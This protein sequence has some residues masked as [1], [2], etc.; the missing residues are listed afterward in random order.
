[1]NFKIIF[2]L[3][4]L[5]AFADHDKITNIIGT[6][7][8]LKTRDHSFAGSIQNALAYG[9]FDH[10]NFTSKSTLHFK[11][12]E[13]TVNFLRDPITKKI[14]GIVLKNDDIAKE[15]KIFLSKID[16]ATQSLIFN[17]NDQEIKVQIE[18]EKF[19]NNHFHNPIYR[20]TINNQQ[21]E[22]KLEGEACYGYS[23][24]LNLMILSAFV[25]LI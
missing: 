13:I 2:F 10:D 3:F 8:E 11:E 9:V 21:I 1:M 18:A 7:I 14:G 5:A 24:H 25:H 6:Q 4:S 20:T 19:E 17:I 22:Y 15:T 16:Q 23:T 12:K